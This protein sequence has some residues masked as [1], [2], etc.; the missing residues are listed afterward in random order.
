MLDSFLH[1]LKVPSAEMRSAAHISTEFEQ[2]AQC[3]TSNEFKAAQ[4]FRFRP[5][6]RSGDLIGSIALRLTSSLFIERTIHRAR[7]G[8][9]ADPKLTKQ[10]RTGTKSAYFGDLD[11]NEYAEL[12]VTDQSFENYSSRS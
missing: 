2:G 6:Q 1:I 11:L 3:G 8:D 9:D 10:T 4:L 12:A 5:L 7:T